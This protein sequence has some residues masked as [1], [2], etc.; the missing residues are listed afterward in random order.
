MLMNLSKALPR[1]VKTTTDQKG[2]IDKEVVGTTSQ[3]AA[4]TSQEVVVNAVVEDLQMKRRNN[5]KSAKTVETAEVV[6]VA[7]EAE[8]PD[9]PRN[10]MMIMVLR[11]SILHNSQLETIERRSHMMV[12]H[13]KRKKLIHL[14]SKDRKRNTSLRIDP[15]VKIAKAIDHKANVG[16]VVV[17]AVAVKPV[18]AKAV[19]AMTEATGHLNLKKSL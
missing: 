7:E 5:T 11:S 6:N 17:V 18:L 15:K 10:L 4:N 12:K 9:H 8:V 16:V 13:Q 19:V 3:E 2:K 14:E 1:E